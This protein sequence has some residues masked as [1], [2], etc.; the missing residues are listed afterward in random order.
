[1][2]KLSQHRFDS[3]ICVLRNMVGP[4]E[5]DNDLEHEINGE[6]QFQSYS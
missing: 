5:V 4:E 1:M 6:I 3:N 2:Q